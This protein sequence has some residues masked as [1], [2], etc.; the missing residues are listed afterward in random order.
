MLTQTNS[1]N[2]IIYLFK[3]LITFEHLALSVKQLKI[4][5]ITVLRLQKRVS[6]F[7][8]YRFLLPDTLIARMTKQSI[9][10]VGGPW[11]EEDQHW[12]SGAH[13]RLS[14][15][16]NCAAFYYGSGCEVLCRPR[17]DAFGHYSCSPAGEI[18]CRSGWTGDYCSKRKLFSLTRT[19]MK[20]HNV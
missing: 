6:L 13:L 1:I 9:A 11:V 19:R 16:V 2:S 10:D 20:T 3:N 4:V 15:R 8:S 12:G 5:L 7:L 18:V 17:D 14:Y